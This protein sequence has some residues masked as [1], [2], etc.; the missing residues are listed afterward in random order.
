MDVLQRL[1]FESPFRLGIFSFCLFAVVLFVR[2]R[3]SGATAR[4][5]LPVTLA[6]IV[7]LFVLQSL[8]T[9]Q[10]EEVLQSLDALVAATEQKDVAA[11]RCVFSPV[12]QSEDMDQEAI[13]GSINSILE[14]LTIQDSRLR[15]KDVTIDGDRAEMILGAQAIVSVRDGV[16]EFH[17]GRWRISWLR[18]PDGWK[19]VSL[20]PEMID[21]RPVDR[22]RHLMGYV[23]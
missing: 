23:P 10:R 3:W 4:Y 8:I 1:F 11:L 12:Y 18:E 15:R 16:G 13:V 7:L 14:T 17:F 20:R 5:S 22:M 21:G 6:V 9:T 2:R 19:I